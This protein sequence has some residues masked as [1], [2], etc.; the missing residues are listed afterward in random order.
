[1]IMDGFIKYKHLICEPIIIEKLEAH[2]GK[3]AVI[4]LMIYNKQISFL[5]VVLVN[6][7]DINPFLCTAR[8]LSFLLLV[9]ILLFLIV[10]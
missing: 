2:E 6:I 5:R 8:V 3:C 1:M 7:V 9:F 10:K 4:Q